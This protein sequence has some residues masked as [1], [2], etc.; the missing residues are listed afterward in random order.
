MPVCT[1]YGSIRICKMCALNLCFNQALCAD[2]CWNIE[3][4]FARIVDSFS[5]CFVYS[6]CRAWAGTTFDLYTPGSAPC[7]LWPLRSS[8]LLGFS[9]FSYFNGRLD[10]TTFPSWLAAW[11]ECMRAWGL[12]RFME[13]SGHTHWI[14]PIRERV[15]RN[16]TLAPVP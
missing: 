2:C 14:D 1:P 13:C 7:Y 9:S 11:N 10:F 12:F 8:G 4:L 5:S 16:I 6:A 3:L 15:Q